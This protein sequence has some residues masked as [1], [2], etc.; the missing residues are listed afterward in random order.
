MKNLL[1]VVWSAL[2]LSALSGCG[3]DGGSE[4][5]IGCLPVA[6][7]DAGGD[8]YFSPDP[9]QSKVA[10]IGMSDVP[11]VSCEWS[12]QAGLSDARS[13][14]PYVNAPEA[15]VLYQLTAKSV[16]NVSVSHMRA[17]M[18][19]EKQRSPEAI[20]TVTIDGKKYP[21]GYFPGFKQYYRA[22]YRDFSVKAGLT[23]ADPVP[24]ELDY[25]PFVQRIFRQECGDCW[26]QGG[27][28]AF[29]AL[30]AL[31]DKQS[32]FL[33]RQWGIDCSGYGTCGG[34]QIM[35][36]A[37]QSPKGSVY[38][39]EYPYVGRTQRCQMPSGP[40][41]EST[42]GTFFVKDL[43]WPNL[44]RALMESGPLEVCGSSSALGNGGWVSRNPGGGTDHCYSLV[45]WYDGAKH[46][47][48]AGEYGIIANSWGTSWGDGGY[49]YYLL[50][51]NGK[52]LDGNVITE[53]AGMEYKSPC[54]MPHADFGP[55]RSIKLIPGLPN[56][57]QIGTPSEAG[58]VY[59]WNNG[60]SLSDANVAQ[61]IASPTR[62]TVYEVEVS[63]ACGRVTAKGT[64]HV[65]RDAT[66]GL[67]E[68]F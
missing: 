8:I 48:P 40:Y 37:F 19:K 52:D 35:L 44:K 33:G 42:K 18:L 50:A 56:S 31:V 55:D 4:A 6:K 39:S 49:G 54:P 58:S 7:A 53:A 32:R 9:A 24:A 57:V 65:F 27:H 28:T 41:H 63:N 10:K 25:K 61:P 36:G 45:G 64:V 5:P 68:S 2:L 17:V 13:C 43:N 23:G 29:E 11:G 30:I 51:K 46:G 59:K 21:T 20:P 1:I 26:S 38:E 34:G 3:K 67:V 12:P 66:T 15:T 47:K 16:C 14:H 22:Q 62:T 60:A